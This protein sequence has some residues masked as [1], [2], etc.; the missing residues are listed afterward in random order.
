MEPLV[1]SGTLG[2]SPTLTR[3]P[4]AAAAVGLW[5]LAQSWAIIHV[6]ILALS[7]LKNSQN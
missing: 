6:F 7:G 1:D 4:P 2:C 5:P 3:T